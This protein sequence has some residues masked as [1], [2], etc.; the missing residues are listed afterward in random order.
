LY[1]NSASSG[2]RAATSS[3]AMI[4]K[5]ASAANSFAGSKKTGANILLQISDEVLDEA[6]S[7]HD[8][9]EDVV[10]SKVESAIK[11]ALKK[12]LK[13]SDKYFKKVIKNK[14]LLKSA[15]K[16]ALLFAPFAI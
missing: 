3:A 15:E 16:R 8:P 7:H 5:I 6:F 9:I 12:P 14:D 13:S 2:I 4:M 1:R 11:K 10:S